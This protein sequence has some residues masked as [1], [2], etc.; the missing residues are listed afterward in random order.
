MGTIA[1]AEL[2]AGHPALDYV[3]TIDDRL[4]TD[5][6]DLLR[7]PGDLSTWGVRAGLLAEGPRRG[8]TD[9]DEFV[10][11]L[12]LRD[13][14]V[15][16]LD[17]RVSGDPAPAADRRAL[18]QAVAAAY[19]AGTLE[20]VD[21]GTLG[22]R[23]DPCD[24]ATVRHVVATTAAQLLAG[25]AAARI[26]RCDGAGCGWFFLDTTKRGNRRWCS[27]QECGQDAK[28]ARRRERALSQRRT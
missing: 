27:M 8:Q 21:D 16:L 19:A 2:V 20:Q 9:R 26:R 3:N 12:A 10:A 14:L 17:A 1:D 25:P 23:W 7:E 5:P 22:W 24:L 28:S 6:A 13:H 15:A 18:A 11:A 4:T